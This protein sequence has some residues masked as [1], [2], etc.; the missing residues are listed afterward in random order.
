MDFHAE[1]DRDTEQL[2]DEFRHLLALLNLAAAYNCNGVPQLRDPKY[3]DPI[4]D[5]DEEGLF[6]KLTAFGVLSAI[7]TVLVRNHEVFAVTDATSQD[8]ITMSQVEP[9][10]MNKFVVL[11]NPHQ[12]DE[13]FPSHST[14][15]THVPVG[16]PLKVDLKVED[17]GWWKLCF[18]KQ[19]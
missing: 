15:C 2:H 10:I 18:E 6:R 13:K 1:A 5:D 14:H 19:L 16:H 9:R 8:V 4:N 3:L 17:E 7:A 11:K 12:E